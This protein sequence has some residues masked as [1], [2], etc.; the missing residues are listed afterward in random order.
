MHRAI[1]KPAVLALALVGA[2]FA[3]AEGDDRIAVALEAKYQVT[4]TTDGA[5]PTLG[6]IARLVPPSGS[7]SFRSRRTTGDLRLAADW[8]FAPQWSLN[9]NIG[10]RRAEGEDGRAYSAGILAATVGYNPTEALNVFV[11]A[12]LQSPERKGGG[13]S[14]ILDVGVAYLLTRDVQLDLS[15][16]KGVRGMTSPRAFVSAGI[17][18]RF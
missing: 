15:V 8:D 13:S 7:G 3:F 4:G 5:M 18:T 6:L 10:I 1:L 12:G 11:D 14:V 16:G 17:S 2:G 9:P